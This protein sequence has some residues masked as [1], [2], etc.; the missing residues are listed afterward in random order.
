LT[1]AFNIPLAQPVSEPLIE[2]RVHSEP[3]K[4]GK[5]LQEQLSGRQQMHNF[6]TRNI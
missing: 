6:Q 2:F 5:Q 3:D 1:Q 4:L